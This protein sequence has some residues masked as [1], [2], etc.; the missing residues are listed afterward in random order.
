MNALKSKEIYPISYPIS[1]TVLVASK[2]LP[3]QE[4]GARVSLVKQ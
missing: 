2:V 1:S 3:K 4:R